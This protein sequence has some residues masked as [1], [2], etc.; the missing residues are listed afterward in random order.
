MIVNYTKLKRQRKSYRK[1][2]A[3]IE[4]N[5][6]NNQNPEIGEPKKVT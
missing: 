3:F 6:A 4:D 5:P 1:D 2:V